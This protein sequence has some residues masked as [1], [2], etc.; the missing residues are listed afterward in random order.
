MV[1]GAG[2]ALRL[3]PLDRL[4]IAYV[5][6]LGL[7]LAWLWR[8]GLPASWHWIVLAHG[9]LVALA[10]LAPAA[11][12]AGPLGRFLGDW[13][14]LLLLGALYGALGVINLEEAHAYD[15]TVQRWEAAVFG[16]QVSAEWIRAAPSPLLSWVMHA[17]YL[18]YYPILYAA[19]LGLWLS[20]RRD[21]ARA[22]ILA[23]MVTFYACYVAFVL[24]PVTGPRYM[25]PLADNAAP[26]TAPALLA[27]WLLNQ[28]DS[29]GAAFPSSHVAGCAVAAVMAWRAWRPLGLAL[30]P[31]AAGLSVAVVYGQ[32]HYAVDALGSLGWAAVVL[33]AFRRTPSVPGVRQGQLPAT[34]RV[35]P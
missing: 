16:R 2:L 31:F 20:G 3:E 5:A 25:F 4:T 10:L 26:Q 18:A 34:A 13:Y 35:M 15:L 7:A 19:P 22:T 21:A 32:F 14:P 28:G 23:L 33:L 8:D 17:C 27:Q 29:W 6:A 30:L 12:T 24:F 11:R 9:L 1:S